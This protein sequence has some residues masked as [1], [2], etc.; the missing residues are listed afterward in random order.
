[1]KVRRAFVHKLKEF[2]F[3][4]PLYLSLIVLALHAPRGCAADR[5]QHFSFLNLLHVLFSEHTVK[6]TV[7]VANA[8][9]VML[10]IL[11]FNEQ[12]CE[13]TK[14]RYAGAPVSYCAVHG[15]YWKKT[16]ELSLHFSVWGTFYVMVLLLNLKNAHSGRCGR[17]LEDFLF[18]LCFLCK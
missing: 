11:L 18:C 14:C 13:I 17:K 16:H 12:L 3:F 4:I 5:K 10:K 6:T 2:G 9:T 15:K 7:N 1:M 8:W